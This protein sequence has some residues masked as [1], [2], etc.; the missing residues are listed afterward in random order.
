MAL[1]MMEPYGLKD[2][3]ILM[4]R[5]ELIMSLEQF[6]PKDD[7]RIHKYED[8]EIAVFI[9]GMYYNKER[10][11]KHTGINLDMIRL[12]ESNNLDLWKGLYMTCDELKN[13]GKYGK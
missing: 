4:T 7:I 13:R 2:T 11:S 6:F 5:Q 1:G 9:N 8:G 3:Y 10:L 12:K